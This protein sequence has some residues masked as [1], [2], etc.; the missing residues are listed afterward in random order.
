MS[1]EEDD[2]DKPY[3]ASERKLEQARQKGQVA[4]SADL[5][6]AAGYA[7]FVAFAMLLGGGALVAAGGVLQGA[8]AEGLRAGPDGADLLVRLRGVIAALAGPLAGW[9][10]VPAA[11]A[12][13]AVIVQGGPVFATA[14]LAPELH[15]ISPLSAIRQRLGL[16]GL[17]EFAKGLV[18]STLFAVVLGYYLVGAL[19]DIIAATSLDARQVAVMMLDAVVDVVLLATAVALVV[20]LFDVIWQ[21]LNHLR[22]NRMSRRELEDEMRES[23]GDPM[24]KGQRRQAGIAIAM[25]Q[26]AAAVPKADVVIVNPTHYAVALAWDRAGGR[27]PV[28]VAKGV[29]DVALHIRRLAAEAGVPVRSDPPTARALHAAV[30][31][32][33]EVPRAHF[34]AV[35]AA[36]RFADRMRAGQVKA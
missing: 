2:G 5:V 6:A 7:G 30:A 33:Q 15:K 35:A 13:L 21:R 3:D 14:R 31:V 27:A 11:M 32:G 10:V 26:A 19:P 8:L 20:G 4:F 34:R 12:L 23:E 22:Q 36:I 16:S 28:C 29:D 1:K 25:N 9:F 24:L 17:V 18:K